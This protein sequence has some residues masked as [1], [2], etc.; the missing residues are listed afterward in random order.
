MFIY[1]QIFEQTYVSPEATLEEHQSWNDITVLSRFI[2][3][4]LF[5]DCLDV[6]EHFPKLL[7]LVTFLANR[8]CLYMKASIYGVLTNVLYSLCTCTNP[9][10]TGKYGGG[11]FSYA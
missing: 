1:L 10:F 8:G 5:N 6:V 11:V 7:C 3:M 2:L 4:L 9:T